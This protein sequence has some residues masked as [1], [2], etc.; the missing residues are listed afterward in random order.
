MR[1]IDDLELLF[2]Y[3]P[4]RSRD[5]ANRVSCALARGKPIQPKL[6]VSHSQH[7]LDS[8]QECGFTVNVRLLTRSQMLCQMQL[9][10]RMPEINEYPPS[11]WCCTVFCWTSAR[12][13]SFWTLTWDKQPHPLRGLWTLHTAQY[14]Q[15]NWDRSSTYIYSLNIA[16]Q[17][18]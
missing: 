14:P 13:T 3:A 5:P 10:V 2:Y 16:R 11:P 15:I 18:Q 7:T 8:C 1:I 12:K 4:S 9:S 17:H 6:L